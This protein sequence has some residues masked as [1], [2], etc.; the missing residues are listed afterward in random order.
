MGAFTVTQPGCGLLFFPPIDGGEVEEPVDEPID[1][2][3]DEPVDEPIDEGEEEP[4]I[5]VLD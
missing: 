1:E 4:P 5:L 2:P 3:V